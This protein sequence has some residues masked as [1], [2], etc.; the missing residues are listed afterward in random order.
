MEGRKYI[1]LTPFY[2][3]KRGDKTPALHLIHPLKKIKNNLKKLWPVH[4][5]HIG[6]KTRVIEEIKLN[7]NLYGRYFIGQ[8]ASWLIISRHSNTKKA[9][10]QVLG[11]L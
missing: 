6:N 8:S 4:E 7:I 5:Y 10:C 2:L 3:L 9:V 1:S 11:V